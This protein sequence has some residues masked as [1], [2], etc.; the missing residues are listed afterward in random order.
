VLRIFLSTVVLG[1]WAP[2]CPAA[3]D[4]SSAH[5]EQH[6]RT[7]QEFQRLRDADP[8]AVLPFAKAAVARAARGGRNDQTLGD[9][10]EMLALAYVDRGEFEQALGPATR[11][12][13]I[14]RAARPVDY[15]LLALA[16]GMQALALF[17]VDRTAEADNVLR[18][19]LASWRNAYGSSDLRLAQKLEQQAQFVQEGFGR[20]RW[21]TELLR[22]AAA[23]REAAPDGS[24]AKLAETLQRLALQEMRQGQLS[25]AD[26]HLARSATL[27]ESEISRDPAREENKAGLAQMLVLR[28][29]IAGAL[30]RQ[31]QALAFA[32]TARH[33]AFDDRLLRAENEILVSA[34]VSTILE[35]A[36]DLDGAIA[37]QKK[38]LQTFQ[39]YED[40]IASNA[41]DAG[42]VGDTQA[43]LADLYLERDDLKA[44]REALAAARASLGD[45]SALR[46]KTA[47]LERKSGNDAAALRHYQEGLRLRKEAATEMTVLFGT[48]RRPEPGPESGRF[49]GEPGTAL[50]LGCAVVLVPGGQFSSDAWLQTR[51]P[52]DPPV[53]LA[54]DPEHLAFRTKA[55]LTPDAFAADA[56]AAMAAARLYPSSAIVFVH[57]Y[58]VSF[59]QALQRAAQL[60]RDLNFDGPL[61]AFSWPSRDRLLRYGTDR[62]NADRAAASLAEFLNVVAASTDAERIH[63]IAHSMGNRVLLPALA[64][65]AAD[66]AGRTRAKFG[67]IIL[68]APAVP[69]SE[70][71]TWVD[72][73]ERGGLRHIT[74]YASGVD[75]AMWAGFAREGGTVLAGAAAN[76]EPLVHRGVESIDI[77]EAGIPGF[78]NLNHDVFASNPVMTEDM[79]QLLQRGERPPS[80]RLPNLQKRTTRSQGGVYWYYAGGG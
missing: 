53:G 21:V 29:G 32:E 52:T 49:G 66:P 11:A 61:F 17:G 36:G 38:V 63:V 34:A 12:V 28:A 74:L 69:R 47:E 6:R 78:A 13:R 44:A 5:I 22:E 46:F 62:D 4:G 43:R 33:L 31:D 71:A 23:I 18:E 8:Q 2:H 51:R 60:A 42:G 37:E 79:R 65:L 45:T 14:R 55:A 10:F 77:S 80:R 73:L 1:L 76:G 27:I 67:E 24:R 58:N 16:Q 59:D 68:A 48:N 57:G 35:Q 39:K 54:T 9:A 75:K 64:E 56:K 25:E 50:S 30:G 3:E 7:M 26:E 20:T 72:A 40:L 41:L 19:Q 15:E 70:F